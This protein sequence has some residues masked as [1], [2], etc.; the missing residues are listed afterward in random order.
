M[1]GS[2]HRGTSLMITPPP[3]PR[4]HHRALGIVLHVLQ[5]T[6]GALFLMSETPLY[7][8]TRMERVDL[9]GHTLVFM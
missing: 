8:T 4:D 3:P 9:G 5:G 6:R 1:H 2:M 7:L